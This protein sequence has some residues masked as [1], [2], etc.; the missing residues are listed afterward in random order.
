[1]FTQPPARYS[2]ATL[3]KTL[4][5]EGIG[6]PSTY[7]SII[8]TLLDREYAEMVEK[9]FKPTELGRIVWS[10]LLANFDKFFAIKFTASM[11]EELD[12][13]EEGKF[14]WKGVLRDFYGKFSPELEK[15]EKKFTVD[16]KLD[17]KCPICG[18][19]LIIKHGRNGSFAACTSYPDCKFTSNYERKEDGSFVLTEKSGDEPSGIECEKCG[20]E[21]VFKSTRFGNVLACP[22][23]P[24]CKNIK[25][26]VKLADGTVKILATGAEVAVPCPKCGEKLTVKAGKNG[27]FIG[28]TGYPK[29]DFTAN[30]KVD[31]KG[32]IHPQVDKVDEN[33]KCEKCGKK[34]VLRKG[35]RGRFF[36]CTG[37][38]ECKNIKSVKVLEDGTITV[39]D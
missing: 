25:N 7:A 26:Y 3:V 28:C 39:K 16:L 27:M 21:M 4:E 35:R 38:P 13:V 30:M 9:R 22:G 17:L 15:A 37:Y 10:L 18:K 24:E 14:T 32:E 33:I 5:Q 19:E 23:Y 34:M 1:M 8:S 36:A 2:E 31:E 12:G 29:C 11:E 20:K 6:R